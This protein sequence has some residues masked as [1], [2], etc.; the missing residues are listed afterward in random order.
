M[1]LK[2]LLVFCIIMA[3][4]NASK[5]HLIQSQEDIQSLIRAGL[6]VHGTASDGLVAVVAESHQYVKN[7]IFS[8]P[9]DTSV[10]YFFAEDTIPQKWNE[11]IEKSVSVEVLVHFSK[12]CLFSQVGTVLL[13][14]TLAM[15]QRTTEVIPLTKEPFRPQSVDRIARLQKIAQTLSYRQ[16]IADLVAQVST[17]TLQGYVRYLTGEDSSLTTRNSYSTGAGS[18]IEAA[19]W[20]EQHWVEN[21]FKTTRQTFNSQFCPNIFG[22]LAGSVYPNSLVILGAHLDDRATQLNSPTQ[23]APGANDDGSGTAMLLEVARVFGS[24]RSTFRYTLQLGAWCGEEQG[25]VGSRYYAKQLATANADVVAM[26][27]GDMI[28]YQAGS[29][30]EL[31][32]VNRYTS[33]TLTDIVKNITATYVPSLR[34]SDTTAC[35][36]DHQSFFENGY[37]SAG[38]VEYGGYTI[39]PQYHQTG[40]LSERS[41]Y[42]FEQIKLITQS[43]LAS[44]ATL[45]EL[46]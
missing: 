27:Q 23:R 4:T 8:T 31:S 19:Q 3:V 30:P 5:L 2:A 20:L 7:S 11:L 10:T 37:E 24:N 18:S 6:K 16:E 29:S 36:S 35:C 15:F 44:I 26:L 21:G 25:L 43:M 12:I 42:S 41:G 13:P 17:E 39:D 32:F 1:A 34:R 28:G 22:E 46:N 9:Y 33:A 14:Q 38:F 40:D 45:A